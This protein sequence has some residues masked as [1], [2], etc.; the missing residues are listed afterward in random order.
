MHIRGN[1]RSAMK[2]KDGR[3]QRKN[4]HRPTVLSGYFLDRESPGKGYRH[5]V[6]KRDVQSFIELI[7]DW[8]GISHKIERIVLVS[9]GEN[10][11]EYAF[12]HREGTSGIFLSAWPEDLWMDFTR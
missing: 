5:V 1:R 12:Y 11:G 8:Q 6:T 9:G 7:P 4:R 3:V 2:V 10:D